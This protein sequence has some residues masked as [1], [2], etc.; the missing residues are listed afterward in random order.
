[1]RVGEQFGLI[2]R[3]VQLSFSANLKWQMILAQAGPGEQVGEKPSTKKKKKRRGA[4]LRD[5]L[6]IPFRLELQSIRDPAQHHRCTQTHVHTR[7]DNNQLFSS[8]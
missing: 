6:V 7:G 4:A 3:S 2:L 1:M 8:I 5:A